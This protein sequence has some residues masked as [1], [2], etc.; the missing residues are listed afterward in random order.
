VSRSTALAR[1]LI[2]V[3]LASGNL[4]HAGDT[5]VPI[6]SGGALVLPVPEGWRKG[7]D[8]GPVPNLSLRSASGPDFRV[9][10]FALVS[11]GGRVGPASAESL[12]QLVASGANNALAQAVEESIP[13][14][15]LKSTDVEGSY[16]TA[17]DRAPKPREFKYLIQGAMLVSGLPVT[18]TILTNDDSKSAEDL[19]L[20]MLRSARRE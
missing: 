18:F 12:R 16:F 7:T 5:R 8:D 20:H 1:C 6:A 17:T 11:P 10:I 4:A 15:E 19:A 14:Q 13:I 9:S 2:A 3:L